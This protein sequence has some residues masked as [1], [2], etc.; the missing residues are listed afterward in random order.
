MPLDTYSHPKKVFNI[1]ITELN[2]L[3]KSDGKA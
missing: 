2:M 1:S 3:H